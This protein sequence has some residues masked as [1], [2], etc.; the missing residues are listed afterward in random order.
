MKYQQNEDIHE[1]NIQY[2]FQIKIEHNVW[3]ISKIN[4][5]EQNFP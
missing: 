3:N 5:L 2:L 1:T 4:I